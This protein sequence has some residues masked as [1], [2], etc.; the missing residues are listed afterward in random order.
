MK[1]SL[2]IILSLYSAAVLG[3]GAY[4]AEVEL[5]SPDDRVSVK[6]N[7]DERVEYAIY[8]QGEEIIAPS[9]LSLRFQMSPLLGTDM[10]LVSQSE[11]T[12]DDTWQPV[13]KRFEKVRNH[14]NELTLNLKEKRFPARELQLIFRAYDDGVAFRYVVPQSFER[15]IPN[16]QKIDHIILA[17]EKTNFNLSDQTVAWATTYNSYDTHQ[18]SEYPL[19]KLAEI[20]TEEL[21]GLPLLVRT[22]KGTYAAITEADLTNWAGMYLGSE[23]GTKE[24]AATLQSRLAPLHSGSGKVRVKPGTPSPWRV[25]MLGETPGALVESEIVMNLN[26]PCAIEDPSWIEPGISAWDHWWSGE[27]K[28]DTNTLK[29][30][31][32]LAADMGWEYMIVDWHWYGDPFTNEGEWGPRP[33]MDITTTIKEVDM[34]EILRFAKERDVKIVLWLLWN[35]ADEQLDEA[36]ALYEKWGVA[37]VKIDF[38]ARDDQ[39]M[40]EWYHKVIKK[41]AEH[42]LVVDFH[43]AYKP[44]GIRRTYPNLVTREGVLGNEYSKWS[45]RITPEHNVTL[46]FTRMLAGPMDYT[47]GG[48]LNRSMDTF[49]T[50]A[51]ATVM[52]TRSHQLAMFVIYDSPFTVAS[53]HPKH[54]KDQPGVEFLKEVPTVWD[55]TKVLQGEVGEYIVMARR[56]GDRWFIGSMTNSEARTIDIPLDFL[57]KGKWQMKS[58]S[59]SDEVDAEQVHVEKG[60]VSKADTLTINM[61]PGGG[62][63]AYLETKE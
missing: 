61:N 10:A 1:F 58:F 59:D 55:D 17:D 2:K 27:V 31:I 56:N 25:V 12:V 57:G 5:R 11:K 46:P 26:D 40:V 8:M 47:P 32:Q 36:F 54:Y 13:L 9:T 34:P 14:Y 15:F 51:P 38:M 22:A 16:Y 19:R 35:H 18:E 63:A 23:A 7:V 42:K 33:N 62:Y 24:G 41:A 28:M 45:S 6:I 21:V 20:G 49:K 53:D 50:G 29:E 43:G 39:D 44:T 60:Q 3:T 37:G 4:A 52:G 30:Y 48:F